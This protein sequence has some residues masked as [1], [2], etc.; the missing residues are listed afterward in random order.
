M[1][2]EFV[3]SL[4]GSQ[5][6]SVISL[7]SP[8]KVVSPSCF[9]KGLQL[10]VSRKMTSGIDSRPLPCFISWAFPVSA[11]LSW[12][13]WVPLRG[14]VSS[15][16]GSEKSD[17]ACRAHCKWS[18]V[19][20]EQLPPGMNLGF[21]GPQLYKRWGNLSKKNNKS[22]QIQKLSTRTWKGPDKVSDLDKSREL[23]INPPVVFAFAPCAHA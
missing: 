23:H 22:L 4:E 15:L 1:T 21:V 9:R 20:G 19:P 10:A 8:W 14:H 3:L 13:I 17:I 7:C 18:L 11:S 12:W 2:L 16:H 6:T 5:L